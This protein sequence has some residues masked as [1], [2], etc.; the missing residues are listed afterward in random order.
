MFMITVFLFQKRTECLLYKCAGQ[1]L[2]CASFYTL[3]AHGCM[4]SSQL[5]A[6][7]RQWN[8]PHQ[9]DSMPVFGI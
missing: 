5:A 7:Y 6:V 4:L 1:M 8:L 3:L 9:Q 2:S